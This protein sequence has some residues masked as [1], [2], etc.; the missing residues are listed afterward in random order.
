M[1]SILSAGIVRTHVHTSHLRQV[2]ILEVLHRDLYPE[3]HGN[4]L[5]KKLSATIPEAQLIRLL[6]FAKVPIRWEMS[7]WH[8]E[9]G[10]SECSH[11]KE[12]QPLHPEFI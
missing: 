4:G 10:R 3:A 2:L 12:Y 8:D 9:E 11:I 7:K 1:L 6:H 5:K